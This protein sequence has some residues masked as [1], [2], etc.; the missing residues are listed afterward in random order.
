MN[1][2]S[3]GRYVIYQKSNVEENY[4][5]MCYVWSRTVQE[6]INLEVMLSVPHCFALLSCTPGIFSLVAC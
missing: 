5:F 4:M 2:P 1:K 6:F 3:D